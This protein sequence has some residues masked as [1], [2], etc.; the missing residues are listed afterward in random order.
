MASL[1]ILNSLVRKGPF[2]SEVTCTGPG[3]YTP[4]LRQLMGPT[5]AGGGAK[6]SHWPGATGHPEQPRAWWIFPEDGFPFPLTPRQ[7]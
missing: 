2:P 6:P 3:T 1:E 4:L 7:S 5:Q